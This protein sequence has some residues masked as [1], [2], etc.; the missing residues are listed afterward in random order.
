M[1]DRRPLSLLACM[2]GLMIPL[3]ARGQSP[4]LTSP[5]ISRPTYVIMRLRGRV[6]SVIARVVCLRDD[7]NWLVL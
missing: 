1:A 3:A 2:A 7:M 6:V 4:P 5:P